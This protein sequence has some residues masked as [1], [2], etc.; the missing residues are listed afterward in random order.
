MRV[1]TAAEYADAE[2][3][4][5]AILA[6]IGRGDTEALQALENADLQAVMGA[7]IVLLLGVLAET[8]TDPG[9]WLARKQAQALAAAAR[10]DT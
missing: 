7:L 5:L 6:A 10:G 1:I 2:R 3:D 8:G 9:Q 4:A